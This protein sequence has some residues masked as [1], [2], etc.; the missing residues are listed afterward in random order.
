[1]LY[2]Y[3]GNEILSSI[4]GHGFMAWEGNILLIL[5]QKM[6]GHIDVNKNENTRS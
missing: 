6:K 3:W 5:E 2:S 4:H 1:M